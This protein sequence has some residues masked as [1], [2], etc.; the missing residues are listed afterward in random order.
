MLVRYL[1]K[2]GHWLTFHALYQWALEGSSEMQ[3]GICTYFDNFINGAATELSP[4]QHMQVQHGNPHRIIAELL[5]KN[6]LHK[7]R[8]YFREHSTNTF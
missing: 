5:K 7:I 4:Q 1:N 2:L 8:A 6:R 3:D